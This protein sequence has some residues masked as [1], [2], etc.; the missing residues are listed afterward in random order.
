MTN[1]YQTLKVSQQATQLEIKQAYRRLVKQFHPDTDS[2]SQ[3][4]N[5][6]RIIQINAA[7]EVLGDCQRRR[8]YDSL[9]SGYQSSKR[10]ERTA[11]A[12]SQ[13][14]RHRQ[15]E[16]DAEAYLDR[17]YQQ[18]YLPLN[19]LMGRILNPLASQIEELS[20]DPFDDE[21]MADFQ[22][23]LAACHCYLSQARQVF[24]AQPNP[25]KLAQV[26]ASLYYCLNH[27]GD[28]IEELELFTLNYD[29][30]HLHTGKE[31]FKMAQ[32]LRRESQ[33]TIGVF[34]R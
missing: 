12:Q 29:D 2:Q 22:D 6:E 11:E 18:I 8:A 10:Q 15:A 13:Y 7:Y 14:Q 31:L 1:H 30:R 5:P 20:A 32:Q 19:R 28:G 4:S 21:L 3:S 26:A 34:L 17:W 16:Q 33:E 27:L 24:S 9:S 25:S 23:Y